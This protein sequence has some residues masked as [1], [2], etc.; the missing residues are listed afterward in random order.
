MLTRPFK[1]DPK[2]IL[3]DDTSIVLALIHTDETTGRV[4]YTKEYIANE[5]QY[6]TL[7]DIEKM[8]RKEYQNIELITVIIEEPLSGR[9]YLWGNY[10]D[11]CWYETGETCGY[12]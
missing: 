1:V 8:I 3:A 11:N 5:G 4:Y 2:Q 12:A 10:G 6:L 7:K 9:I